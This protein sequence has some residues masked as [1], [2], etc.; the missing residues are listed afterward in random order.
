MSKHPV[1]T[2]FTGYQK[3]V[4][5]ILA[6]LQFTIILDFM[7]I[8]P[9]GAM[10]MPALQISPAQFGVVVSVYAF[11][12]GT[13]GLLAAGFADRFDRKNL[14]LFF[15]CGF[16]LGTLLCGIAPTYHFLLMARMV[17]GVFGGVM[18][19]IVMAITTDLFGFH[20]RGRV[21]GFL[22]TAFSAS[23]ILGI[24][25]GLLFSNQ[26]GWH[27]PFLMIVI[28]SSAV[29][30]VIWLKL[31][32]INA[33]LAVKPDK[34]PFHHLGQTLR[35]PRY[36]QAFA[37]TALL[38]T[39]G[40]MLMPFGSAFSV[41]NLGIS[42]ERLPIVY[43]ATG[44]CSM[45]TG[46]IMGRMSDMFGKFKIFL[47]GSIVTTV[48]VLIYTRLGLTPIGWVI[49]VNAVLFVGISARMISSQALMS[50]IPT[51]N[52]RGAF[53]SVGSSI[54]QFSGGLASMVAGLI[55]LENTDGSL[56]HFDILGDVV[57]CATAITLVLMYFIHKIV[58]EAGAKAT[59]PAPV[60]PVEG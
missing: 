27:A 16:V 35:T 45:F 40:F 58:P 23:Q 41:H 32:P 53:M 22:G 46:P 37:T 18:G 24:P 6:F 51:P 5:A 19:S 30:L 29:G 11:A 54:Q 52:M 14:L 38:S 20:M 43:L 56:S 15:Y 34:S 17:T 4:I 47:F 25:L 50:A 31:K 26:W 21:M 33:H 12:A 10:L 55:V 2:P 59:N 42:L 39:G 8:S 13:S 57:I 9:M 60:Q 48:M 49:A 44:V 7:I 36:L 1:V 3:F 28:V